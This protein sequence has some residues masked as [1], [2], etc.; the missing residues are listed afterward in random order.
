MESTFL[1]L[2]LDPHTAILIALARAE[3]QVSRLDERARV[4]AVRV[5]WLAR[6]DFRE[7]SAWAWNKG[8]S[9]PIEDLVLHDAQ[10]DVRAPDQ[11][12]TQ[13]YEAFRARR[14]ATVGGPELISWRG[15]VW[16]AG[17]VRAAPPSGPRPTTT[18]PG[19]KAGRP[20]GEMLAVLA[21]LFARLLAARTTDDPRASFEDWTEVID[22]LEGEVPPLLTAAAA[23]EAW[24]IIDPLP[25]Q[26]FV[27]PLLVGRWLVAQGRVRMGLFPFEAGRRKGGPF[28]RALEHGPLAARLCYWLTAMERAAESGVEELRQLDLARQV[29]EHRLVGRR[30]TSKAAALITLLLSQPVV[31]AATVASRLKVSQQ[32]ARGLI[33]SLGASLTEISGRRRYRAWRV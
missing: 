6:T 25:Q 16:L 4:S 15:A 31:T 3:D 9:A 5:G 11:A 21:V 14:K 29:L 8:R 1:D 26:S 24:R 17:R 20:S 22:A 18:M 12:L 32:A 2:D 13:A 7:A 28:T 27:G 10:A 30:A 23:L 19:A 33:T